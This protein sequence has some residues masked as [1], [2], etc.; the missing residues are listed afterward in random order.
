MDQQTH[1][2]ALFESLSAIELDA[3]QGLVRGE[4]IRGLAVRRLITAEEAEEVRASMR[5]KL[6][7]ARD[8]DAVRIALTTGF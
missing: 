7:A 5:S 3:L 8:V 1:D 2:R 4:S 6:G